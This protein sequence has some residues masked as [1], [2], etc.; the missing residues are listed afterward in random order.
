VAKI[1]LFGMAVGWFVVMVGLMAL[2]YAGL[3]IYTAVDNGLD[4]LGA[5]AEDFE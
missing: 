1:K 4:F 2:I 3:A 5:H